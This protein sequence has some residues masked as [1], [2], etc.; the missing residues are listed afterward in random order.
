MKNATHSICV[1]TDRFIDDDTIRIDWIEKLKKSYGDLVVRHTPDYG[2]VFSGTLFEET[3]VNS[4]DLSFLGPAFVWSLLWK[5][6]GLVL[7]PDT[8]LVSSL[9]SYYN[10]IVLNSASN[11]STLAMT[12]YTER[13]HE[14][15]GT[16]LIVGCPKSGT[17][18]QSY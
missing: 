11:G 18:L 2:S 7:S 1:V 6:G 15:P 16:L 3:Y 14:L 13:H 5:H 4:A 12:Q 10:F 17:L 8:L 9:S